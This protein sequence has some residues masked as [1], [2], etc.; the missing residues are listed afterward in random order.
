MTDLYDIKEI[1][2]EV[3]EIADLA[4]G[5]GTK[6]IVTDSE[7]PISG[8]EFLK[9]INASKEKFISSV[10]DGFK[11]AQTRI[12]SCIQEIQAEEEIIVTKLK[13]AKRNRE[14]ESI[15][16]LKTK[17]KYLENIQVLFKHCADAILWQLIQGQLYI[18]RRLFQKVEGSKKLKDINLKSVQVVVDD[19][20]K[21]PEDFLLISDIT[22]NVQVGDI[23]GIMNG[24]FIIGEVKEGKKN[25]E[26]LEILSDLEKN[27]TTLEEVHEKYGEDKKFIQ[28]L[29]RN[30]KQK[31]TLKNVTNIINEDKGIDPT[32]NK[33]IKIITPKEHT[34]LYTE[35]LSALEEQLKGR[36]YWAY[37]VI[38]DCLHIGIYK[39]EKRFIG[40]RLLKAI[41]EQAGSEKYIIVDVLKTIISLNKPIFFLPFSP[42]FIFD[43]LF[44]RIK[45]YYM[46]ELNSFLELYSEFGLKAEWA[47]TKETAKAQELGKDY[48][49]F[50]YKNQGVKI[51]LQEKDDFE[52]WLSN[53]SF[54]R[55]FF[56]HIYPSYVAYSTLYYHDIEKLPPT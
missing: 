40:S 5:H 27:N 44:S 19:V 53:G 52:G 41:A 35:R 29:K 1:E 25:V 43:I 24:K 22:N 38:D 54:L 21:K 26:V 30:I 20:N 36:N 39:G 2:N 16:E 37:D 33:E 3:H 55:I 23:I 48:G 46:L 31:T 8:A 32:S 56:E 14:K 50:T 49:I 42:D 11:A 28:Q 4:C 10:H 51:T 13:V 17:E 6:S 12:I 18:S 45:I 9:R 15:T 47:S 34:P 7:Y